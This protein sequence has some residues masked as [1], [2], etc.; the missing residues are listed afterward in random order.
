MRSQLLS[1]LCL[2]ILAP[3]AALAQD[4]TAAPAGTSIWKGVYTDAQ[5]TRGEAEQQNNCAACH[6]TEKYSGEAF[7]KGW[8]GR[9]AF[10][11]FDQIKT[12]MPDDNP[13]GLSVQQYT[14]VVAYIFKI[15]GFPAGAD[16]LSSDPEAL[17][18]IK[19]EPKPAGQ[20][21]LRHS[22]PG[23]V[24]VSVAV[25]HR[26]SALLRPNYHPHGSRTP[27]ATR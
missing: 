5:A 4:T 9:T 3:S 2:S 1:A 22:V 24:G 13:G 19:I 12:T 21:S 14:D 11:L 25:S 20:T 6:G 17:R 16:S 10:D 7:T 27:T 15:N 8:V 23:A 26:R 18:Q